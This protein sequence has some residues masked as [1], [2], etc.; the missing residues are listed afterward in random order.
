MQARDSYISNSQSHRDNMKQLN[1]T[2]DMD[3]I[4]FGDNFAN[5]N[6]HEAIRNE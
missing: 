2:M 3:N 4:P 1:Q 6:Q 5:K